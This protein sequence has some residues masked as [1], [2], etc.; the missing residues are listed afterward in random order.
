MTVEGEIRTVDD[1]NQPRL[2]GKG[3]SGV[4]R[5]GTTGIE[6]G[7]CT[8]STGE[9]EFGLSNVMV[10][11]WAAPHACPAGTW[12]CTLSERGSSIEECDTDRPDTADYDFLNCDGSGGNSDPNN[13]L[14]WIASP[15]PSAPNQ[16]CASKYE[17]GSATATSI[18]CCRSFPV[19]CCSEVQP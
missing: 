14:G 13:H 17:I 12:V 2:W 16:T 3:R 19:W 4:F 15:L 7:L 18:G 9:I 6:T 10:P 1:A 8:N 5:Y 11:W